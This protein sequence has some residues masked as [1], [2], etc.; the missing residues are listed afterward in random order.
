LDNLEQTIKQC[1]RGNALAWEA[2][3]KAYQG[4]VY[5]VAFYMLKDKSEA[6]DATQGA[7]IKMYRGLGKFRSDEQSFLPWL[8]TISRNCCLDKLRKSKSKRNYESDS[9]V[10]AD[11]VAAEIKSPEGDSLEQ[12]RKDLMYQAIEKFDQT[13]K[14]VLMMK[15]IQGLKTNEVAEALS[16]PAGT[17]KSRSNR[18][19]LKLAKILSGFAQF[20]SKSSGI[21]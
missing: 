16:L 12:Q 13:S 6:E 1:Q 10:D 8:L 14:D 17:V 5:G 15:D 20:N 9:E 21:L 11:L 19:K 3:I 7:F 18:A 2:L 4:R